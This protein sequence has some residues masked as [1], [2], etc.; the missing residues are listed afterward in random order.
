MKKR[1]MILALLL[2]FCFIVGCQE[3][4]ADVERFVEDGVEVVINHLEPYKVEREANTLHLVEELTI[5]T[6]NDDVAATGLTFVQIF[7]VDSEGNLYFLNRKSGKNTVFKFDQNGNFITSFGPKGGG[8]GELMSPFDLRVNYM[9]DIVIT[10]I[11]G[12]FVVFGKNGAYKKQ[13][14][15]EQITG[16]VVPLEN[17]NYLILKRIFN[18]AGNN[19]EWPLFLCG[20]KFETIKEIGRHKAPDFRGKWGFPLDSFS[21]CVSEGKIFIGNS[22]NGYEISV[23]DL[24]GNLEKKIR[25]KFLPA[26]VS[27]ELKKGIMKRIEGSFMKEGIFFRNQCPAFQYFFTD[28]EGHFFAM[29]YEAGQSPGEYIF[30]VFNSSGIFVSR[31]F[32]G[33]MLDT[34]SPLGITRRIATAKKG[35]L[36][37]LKEKESGYLELVIYRM[38]WE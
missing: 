24:A 10:D 31:I 30:D 16:Q 23:F 29:T 5:D 12:K 15:T 18:P 38:L 8:P 2:L 3:K 19:V 37:C 28:D 6:E 22:E 7:D 1:F 25:K 11:V 14:K 35:R 27:E 34:F 17:G 26:G 13:V 21:C 20:P 32:M 9:G 33:N 36:Y 4:E